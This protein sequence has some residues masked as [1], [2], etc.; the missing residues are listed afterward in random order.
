MLSVVLLAALIGPASA[1]PPPDATREATAPT[2]PVGPAKIV[3]DILRTSDVT[4]ERTSL[5]VQ[6]LLPDGH[7]ALFL[8]DSG[9]DVS[10][11]T[12]AAAERLGL[13]IIR[14]VGTLEGL[15]GSTPFHLAMS[16]IQL[17]DAVLPRVEFAVGLR[18][19][20]EF[21]G[22]MPLEGILGT[23]VWSQFDMEID[24]KN[25]RIFL[26][27]PGT[28]KLPRKSEAMRFIDNKVFTTI[29]LA[30]DTKPAR[31]ARMA[32]QVDTGAHGLVITGNS[33]LDIDAL[34][35]DPPAW[36]Q[37]VE[38]IAGLGAADNMPPSAFLR[39][40]RRLPLQSV[41]L[42]GQK[43]PVNLEAQWY[44]YD[45]ATVGPRDMGGLL[46]HEILEGHRVFFAFERGRFAVASSHRPERKLDGHEVFLAQDLERYGADASRGLVRGRLLAA[47]ERYE[48]SETALIGFLGQPEPTDT[49]G[50]SRRAEAQMTLSEVRRLH[51]DLAGASDALAV[52]GPA[53]LVE[54]GLVLTAVNALVLE[55]KAEAALELSDRAIRAY[56]ALPRPA[57]EME[58]GPGEYDAIGASSARVARADAL[59]G[60]RRMAD[61]NVTLRE[62]TRLVDNPDGQLIRRARVALAQGDR[63][64]ALAYLRRLLQLYPFNGQS[65]WFYATLVEAADQEMF[66]AD[67]DEAM[68]RLHPD[69]RPLDY[70]VVSNEILG[71]HDEAAR[72]MAEGIERDCKGIT[73]RP[74]RQNCDAWYHAL[75]GVELDAA[76][77]GIDD[78]LDV[79]GQRSDFLDTKA[80][81]HLARGEVAVAADTALR[82]A[83]MSPD[84]VYMLWQAER[85][86]QIAAGTPS[87]L[88]PGSPAP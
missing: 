47:L 73:E 10:V 62:A 46:G 53:D 28:M 77:S 31:T 7:P 16:P 36:T 27:E 24:Y 43:V 45:A 20:P 44:A 48:P 64:G 6:A 5:F 13:P 32:V 85:I 58:A 52:L 74:Q 68:A 3:L 75:G 51:G 82:A 50:R 54:Q 55:G 59:F 4:A 41:R 81:V 25:D 86:A 65:L 67:L 1:A 29:T 19:L 71:R 23:N 63:Y 9:A 69:Q 12:E 21:A 79:A 78:A 33:K 38:P 35:G 88:A 70:L 15:G 72:Y 22:A 39:V 56:D 40:T 57:P 66:F 30:T 42:G 37:G 18:G 49:E 60:L 76:L 11:M 84:D 2:K 26:Y 8:V 83:R 80:M 87:K 14:N 34:G 17:G 61:A